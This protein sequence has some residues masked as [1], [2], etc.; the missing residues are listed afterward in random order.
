[1][2]LLVM[3]VFGATTAACHSHDH[4][5]PASNIIQSMKLRRSS[6]DAAEKVWVTGDHEMVDIEDIR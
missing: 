1:M 3:T 5:V 6:S 4:P 2:V